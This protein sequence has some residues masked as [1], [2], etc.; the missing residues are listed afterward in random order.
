MQN[1]KLIIHADRV[2]QGEHRGQYNAPTIDEV[3]VCVGPRNIV[4]YGRGGHLR[5]IS[6]L[7]RSYDALQYPLMYTR[8]EDGYHIN[9]LHQ[10]TQYRTKTVSC[11]QFYS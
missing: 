7:N 2:P 6:E 10:N 9:I 8:G 5:R 4:L 3:A 11:M 1:F